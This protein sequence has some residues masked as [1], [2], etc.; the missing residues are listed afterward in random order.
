MCVCVCALACACTCVYMHTQVVL[1]CKI[2]ITL[3]CRY[4]LTVG[5]QCT[6][7]FQ[8]SSNSQIAD[9]LLSQ[10]Y[11]IDVAY[12]QVANKVRQDERV[13][14]LERFNVRNL[15]PDNI[16]VKVWNHEAFLRKKLSRTQLAD[17]EVFP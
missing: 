16:P 14:L 3:S 5:R 9:L 11:G 15:T 8:Q 6:Y 10:V 17:A 12:G 2:K 13:T 7:G 1:A 4:E